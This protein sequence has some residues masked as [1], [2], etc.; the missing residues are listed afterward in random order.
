[1]RAVK[2]QVKIYESALNFA[3]G[4]GYPMEEIFIPKKKIAFNAGN[5]GLNVFKTNKARGKGKEIKLD[6][7]FVTEIVSL[8]KSNEKCYKLAQ[9][10]FKDKVKK[11]NDGNC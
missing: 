7:T 2:Y 11:N 1:M 6:D 5:R 10:Y 8:F 3:H 4:F 9:V